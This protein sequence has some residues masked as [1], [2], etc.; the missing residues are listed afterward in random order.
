MKKFFLS[1]FFN[2]CLITSCSTQPP[3][4][5]PDYAIIAH[6][7]RVDVGNLLSKKYN[8]NFIGFSGS[9]MDDVKEIGLSFRCTQKTT[10]EEA[11]PLVIA[12]AEE[13]LH[14]VNANEEIRPYLHN[15]PFESKNISIEIFLCAPGKPETLPYLDL[16]GA[17]RG[18]IYYYS[19]DIMI[20]HKESYDKAKKIIDET[21]VK[22]IP[23]GK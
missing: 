23:C 22:P 18:N 17:K 16:V 7:L 14:Q 19:N 4:E 15:Y 5:R 9:M 20:I 12:C 21:G 2:F 11:R 6:N 3:E 13:L 1:L 10:I 8:L